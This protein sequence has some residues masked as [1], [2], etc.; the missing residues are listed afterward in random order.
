MAILSGCFLFRKAENEWVANDTAQGKELA[1]IAKE[2]RK[3]MPQT[4]ESWPLRFEEV[5]IETRNDKESRAVA[6][7]KL[8]GTDEAIKTGLRALA[9][10]K[11]SELGNKEVGTLTLRV[12]Y[13]DKEGKDAGHEEITVDLSKRE[14]QVTL[15]QLGANGSPHS[16]TVS[17]HAVTLVEPRAQANTNNKQS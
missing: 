5:K 7:W 1:A 8:V 2:K 6:S 15:R 3:I 13:K 12:Q 9:K 16:A 17:L 14:G 4:P 11:Q 10:E